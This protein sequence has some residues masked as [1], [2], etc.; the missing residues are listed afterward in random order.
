MTTETRE[1][2]P[3]TDEQGALPGGDRGA[4]SKRDMSVREFLAEGAR[5]GVT[6]E[7]LFPE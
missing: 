3:T 6:T 2:H 5:R 7:Q 4:C 1:E